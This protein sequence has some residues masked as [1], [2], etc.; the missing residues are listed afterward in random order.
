MLK[1][2]RRIVRLLPIQLDKR[3]RPKRRVRR[4][5]NA[6]AGRELQQRRLHQVRMV[7][8]LQRRGPDARVPQQIEDQR[9]LEIRDAD[10]ARQPGIDQV[11]QRR[12]R[13]LDRRV[14]QLHAA[15]GGVPAWRVRD[16]WIDVLQRDGEVHD[17]EVEIVDA[18]VCE[19][20]LGDGGYARAVV[21][22]V[23]ELGDEEEV[24]ALYE[25]VFDGSRDALAGFF[26]IAVVWG[27]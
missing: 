24:G 9:A 16:R 11:L 17:V 10:A 15:V 26:F 18:P 14:A 21:E 19:L 20:L 13:L 4:H 12:P 5:R 1:Q 23:P 7:L 25:A 6:L 3:L 8:D 22:G 27:W 2:H